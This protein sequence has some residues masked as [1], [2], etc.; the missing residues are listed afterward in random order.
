MPRS[1]GRDPQ[2]EKVHFIRDLTGGGKLRSM[3]SPIRTRGWHHS[4]PPTRTQA[5]LRGTATA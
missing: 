4:A 5:S 3:H 1:D 2:R